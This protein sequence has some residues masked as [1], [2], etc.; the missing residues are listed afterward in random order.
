MSTRLYL[1]VLP[2]LHRPSQERLEGGEPTIAS[3]VPINVYL[4]DL[5]THGNAWDEDKGF[6]DVVASLQPPPQPACVPGPA[7]IRG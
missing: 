5:K 1:E 7:A 3:V 4:N 2:Y 6:G